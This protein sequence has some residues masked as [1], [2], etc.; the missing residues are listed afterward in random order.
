MKT[1]EDLKKDAGDKLT[2]L[3]LDVL[4][5]K[6][7]AVDWFYNCHAPGFDNQTPLEYCNKN[8]K[9]KLYS[10]LITIVQGNIGQ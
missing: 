5:E 9:D 1:L 4:R 2:D 3:I 8:G 7:Y 10:R 6:D